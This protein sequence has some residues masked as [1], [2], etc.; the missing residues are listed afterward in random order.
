VIALV[1]AF[2]LG[3]SDV[4]LT[5]AERAYLEGRYGDAHALF[6]A[7]RREAVSPSGA[8]LYNLGNCA[9]RLGRP[10]EAV[11]QYRRARLR[12]PRDPAVT[13]NLRLAEGQLGLYDPEGESFGAAVAELAASFTPRELLV[14]VGV[15]ETLG[16]VGVVLLRRKRWLRNLSGLVLLLGLAGAARLVVTQWIPGAPEG[17]VLDATAPVHAAPDPGSEVTA[18]L[19]PGESVR[20]LERSDGWIRIRHSEG[21]GWTVVGAVGILTPLP[22]RWLDG[23]EGAGPE[24][25]PP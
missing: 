8:L 10:A 9:Y 11:L 15:L 22:D 1:L 20:A 25:N 6:E 17:V 3:I 19:E 2:V 16:L 24:S 23:S 18:D 12:L 21:A 14:A 4:D 5:E 13:F 7:A